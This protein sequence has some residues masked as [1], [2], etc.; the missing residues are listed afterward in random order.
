M[1][2][3]GGV[4]PVPRE[5][6]VYQGR[7]AGLVSRL[8]A[9]AVDGAVVGLVMLVGYLGYAGLLFMANP[10][11]FVFPSGSWLLSLTA[12][13]L[14]MVLYLTAAWTLTGRTYGCHLMGLRVVDHQARRLRFPAAFVRALFCTYFPLG[15]LW[16]AVN[17]NQRSVQDLV[18]RTAVLYDWQPRRLAGNEGEGGPVPDR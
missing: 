11:G 3:E 13:S 1:E 4:S 2:A 6:R 15:L 10:R 18:L 12:A 16:C 7:R 9:S 17:R 14:V 5:A 8:V